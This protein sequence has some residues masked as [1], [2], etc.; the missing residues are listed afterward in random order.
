MLRTKLPILTAF[1][2]VFLLLV[3]SLGRA[4]RTYG[5]VQATYVRNYD[6]DTIT[7]DIENWPPIVGEAVS[8]RVRG[9]DTP[10]MRGGG[11]RARSAKRFTGRM[12]RKA[13]VIELRDMS[14]GKY[15]RIVADVYLDEQNLA[16]ALLH[17]G[18]ADRKQ[19]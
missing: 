7:V 3:T 1:L 17:P 13:D 19:Y 10:E 2:A 15:F 12:C 4:E 5:H 14:R 18:L 9:I 8:V 16:N 6:G 11:W